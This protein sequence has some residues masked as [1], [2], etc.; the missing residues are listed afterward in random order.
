MSIMTTAATL[1]AYRDEL[2]EAGF[3]DEIIDDLVRLA[4]PTSHLDVILQEKPRL[5]LSGMS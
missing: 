5:T 4:A 3:E 1:A 2:R